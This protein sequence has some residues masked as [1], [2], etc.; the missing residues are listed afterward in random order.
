MTKESKT[1]QLNTADQSGKNFVWWLEPK[2]DIYLSAFAVVN[3]INANQLYRN[4]Q[5]LKYARLYQNMALLGLTPSTHNKMVGNSFTS[6][7]AL[8]VIKSCVDTA[9]AKIAS[10][11]PRPIFL[12]E[13]GDYS[14][15][16]RAKYLTK[17]LEGLFDDAKVYSVGQDVFI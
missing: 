5:N 1:I 6:R 9:A 17:Y 10:N 12:T 2:E 14:L 13:N 3:H 11:K 7:L 15:K 16:R 4:S 8:N